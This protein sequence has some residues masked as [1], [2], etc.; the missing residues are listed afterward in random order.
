[1]AVTAFENELYVIG[2]RD[3]N[4]ITNTTEKYNPETDTWSVMASKIVSTTDIGA[5]SLA[6]GI[7]VPGGLMPDGNPTDIVEMF[8]PRGNNWQQK[9]PLPVKISAYAIA[10]FEGSLYIFGG[11]DGKQYINSVYRYDPD[12]DVWL[13]QTPMPSARGYA[14]AAVA[15]GK[16]YVLGGKNSQQI[17]DVNEVYQPDLDSGLTVPWSAATPLPFGRSKMGI[18]NIADVIYLLGGEGPNQDFVVLAYDPRDESWGQI[19]APLPNNWN[20]LGSYTIGTRLY[21]LGGK[22]ETG[23]VGEMWG[24]QALFTISLPIVR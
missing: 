1:M 7:Y 24:F 16:I 20:S 23:L 14:S 11:W 2:G 17:L 3:Y 12:Q 15:G 6:G 5:A 13:E 10:A 18:A 22:T 9:A 8:D 19:E 21:A 4:G